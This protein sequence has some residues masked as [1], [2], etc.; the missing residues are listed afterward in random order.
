M[1]FGEPG[2][3]AV[4]VGGSDAF[5]VESAAVPVVAGVAHGVGATPH[6]VLR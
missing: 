1:P 6:R 4:F 5:K 3:A 2:L